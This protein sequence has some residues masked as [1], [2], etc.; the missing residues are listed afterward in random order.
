MPP[1]CLRSRPLLEMTR[2]QNVHVE[3]PGVTE[4]HFSSNTISAVLARVVTNPG[5]NGGN[6][7][8]YNIIK[9]EFWPDLSLDDGGYMDTKPI[10]T[11]EV[12]VPPLWT[13][14]IFLATLAYLYEVSSLETYIYE[15]ADDG[16]SNGY[17]PPL[18][19]T[20]NNI[21]FLYCLPETVLMRILK[22]KGFNYIL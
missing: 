11:A 9:I 4:Q 16:I 22:A 10:F 2:L 5:K 1:R 6:Q 3:I 12:A 7:Q 21:H 15:V 18:F 17:L 14:R 8:A 19:V 20:I 13:P